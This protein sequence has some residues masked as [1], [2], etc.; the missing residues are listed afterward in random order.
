MDAANIALQS[1]FTSWSDLRDRFPPNSQILEVDGAIFTYNQL[2]TLVD[3]VLRPRFAAAGLQPGERVAA[4]L[5]NG[6]QA[7]LMF[8][9]TPLCGLCFCPLDP[10]LTRQEL[11]FALR[12]LPAKALLRSVHLGS[13]VASLADIVARELKLM[14]LYLHTRQAVDT[15]K[16]GSYLDVEIVSESQDHG[17]IG[18]LV[19][20]SRD[21]IALALHTSGTTR[22]AKLVP[23][24]HGNLCSGA[25]CIA[26]TLKIQPDDVVLNCLPL[27]HIHGL[28]VNVLVPAIAGAMSVCLTGSFDAVAAIKR[29]TVEPKITLYSAVPTL[30]QA[31]LAIYR[32]TCADDCYDCIPNSLRL[33][34]NCSAHLPA[35][36]AS[37][38]STTLRTEV[39]PTYAMTESMPIASPNLR[40]D[41]C[42]HQTVGFAAGPEVALLT[43]GQ[44]LGL[45]EGLFGEVCVRGACVT[46]GYEVREGHNPNE[47]TFTAD[48]WLKTG[49]LGTVS[50]DGLILSGRCKEVINKAG[51][52]FS[53]LQI[54]E[55][56]LQ[57]PM[58]EDCVAFSATCE[59]RGEAI[60]LAII[61]STTSC[62][63]ESKTSHGNA[64]N[65][66][67]ERSRCSRCNL[68]SLRMF[69]RRTQELRVAALPDCVIWIKS[70]PRTATGKKLRVGLGEIL[71]IP[72]LQGDHGEWYATISE[73]I[74]V[75]SVP[76]SKYILH[77][78]P[79][80]AVQG[81]L[82]VEASAISNVDAVL[83]RLAQDVIRCDDDFDDRAAL[84]DSGIDSL[85]ATTFINSLESQWDILLAG[86]EGAVAFLDRYPS[87]KEVATAVKIALQ[88][89]STDAGKHSKGNK[90][91]NLSR[92]RYF[93]P[94][95]AQLK[96][97]IVDSRDPTS[98]LSAAQHGSEEVIR[99]RC[100]DMS[101]DEEVDKNGLTALH[102]AAGR[103]DLSIVSL[104]L[105]LKAGVDTRNKDLR[106][107]LMKGPGPPQSADIHAANKLGICCLHWAAWGGSLEAVAFLLDKHADIN[108]VCH[109]GCN[110]A[111]WAA[112]AGSFDMCQW[113]HEKRADFAS[114]NKNG[115][116]VLNK[117]AWRGHGEKLVSWMLSLDGV[118]AQ[119]Y[120]PDWDG[121]LPLD[122]ARQKGH[123]ALADWLEDEIFASK[124]LQKRRFGR[125]GLGVV[126]ACLAEVSC[127][128]APC[129]AIEAARNLVAPKMTKKKHGE[130]EGGDFWEKHEELLKQAWKE[131]EPL[132][133]GLYRYGPSFEEKYVHP[134]LRHAVEKA[135]E[136][137]E[138]ETFALFE[139]IVPG[140][141]ATDSLFTEHFLSEFLSEVDSINASGIPTR[142]PNGMNRYGVILDEEGLC[143]AY[144]QPLAAML[145][146]ELVGPHDVDGH[147]AFTVKYE[148]EG[149]TEL[150]K[151]GDAA[152][153]TINLCLG[154]TWE[155]SELRFFESGGSGMYQLPKGNESA[156][157]GDVVFRSGMALIHRG[158]HQH[159]AQEL[160]SGQ[161]VNM[162][163]WLHSKDGVVRI[164]P[165]AA[166]EQMTVAQRWRTHRFDL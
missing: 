16:N 126:M 153:V 131:R 15:A 17:N 52:K 98:L 164:A 69:G 121:E 95:S 70:L 165:Y 32:K 92:V 46:R 4:L 127:T 10:Q 38:I 42:T 58:I 117:V 57:H 67:N 87:L 49:D 18:S 113:L 147:Y 7:A 119:L 104:L 5:P 22:R 163:I 33:I 143:K 106:T 72:T 23:L 40:C 66:G 27:F 12:D 83:K 129:T 2:K 71:G 56:Y 115:H 1:T 145:F 118:E 14:I 146:P 90:A 123:T 51:E 105:E 37:A 81:S 53:P 128:A 86:D 101:P 162:V 43:D 120:A 54:E 107:P 34:R 6:P 36:L 9:C 31:L 108:A 109:A 135:R 84:M 130:F 76:Y 138:R 114:T 88:K 112:T 152:V 111:V 48:G 136:G 8:L 64:G 89:K 73:S 25:L 80:F 11:D 19:P 62:A 137:Q 75:T 148:A 74:G 41:V 93:G 60:G 151:H 79:R 28:A 144:L 150:A 30:H 35:A 85:S 97:F 78:A 122:R 157:A 63:S 155:G 47:D 140:V 96:Q 125:V 39:L 59:K 134:S 20:Q 102:Y 26:S 68:D 124:M 160:L 166:E 82:E 29:L 142:R 91:G 149:D 161:R 21:E 3:R 139:E 156:G 132:H 116:G 103:G 159:Q 133:S 110:V 100:K 44:I 65:I 50:A 55:V 45:S 13:G 154:G 158:Q 94:G 141:F 61:E 99:C 77:P 24:S